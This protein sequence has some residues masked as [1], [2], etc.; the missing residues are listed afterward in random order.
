MFSL[1]FSS[2][3]VPAPL[4]VELTMTKDSAANR[5]TAIRIRKRAFPFSECLGFLQDGTGMEAPTV[6]IDQ[7]FLE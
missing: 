6:K 1:V 7:G 4:R 2:D 3:A 5:A